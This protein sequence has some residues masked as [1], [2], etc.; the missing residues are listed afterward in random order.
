M[1][2]FVTADGPSHLYTAVI[3]KSLLFHPHSNYASVYRLN[4]RLVPNW[5]ATVVLGIIAS[6]FGDQRAEKVMI[7]LCLCAGFFAFAYA[8]RSFAPEAAP[9][10]PLLNFLLQTWFLCAGFQ[11]FYLGMVLCPLLIGFYVRNAHRMTVRQAAVVAAGLI[12]LFMTHLVAAGFAALVLTVISVWL[13]LAV[14]R[15]FR[16]IGFVMMALTPVAFLFLVFARSSEQSV[17][18]RPTL[19]DALSH[20]PMQVFATA[21]GV[22]GSQTYLWPAV[23]A[24]IIIAILAMRPAEWYGPRGGLALAVLA[25]FALYLAV[26]ENGFG[27]N[28]V[29]VRFSWGFFILGTLL[30]CSVRRLQPLRTPIAIYVAA[31]LTMNLVS[32]AQT[33]SA[34]SLAVEDY[35]TATRGLSRGARFV[36]LRYPTP[37]LPTRYRFNE[38]WR[39]PLFHLDAYVAAR[40]RC[41]DLSDYQA[42]NGVFPVVFNAKIDT[43]QRYSLWSLEGP[44]DRTSETLE[45]LRS[46]LPDP[47]DYVVIVADQ[48]SPLREDREKL[49]ASLDSEMRVV[50]ETPFIRVYG[51]R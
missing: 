5:S 8:I 32:S 12:G 34:Y 21:D 16:Q 20:F 36:R 18:L 6:L 2:N 49:E 27:G 44:G 39:D 31:F 30:A 40:C 25:V 35:L 48:S 41:I 10:T 17:R 28:Q 45:W 50:A 43:N 22:S 7:D 51:K 9:W 37:D 46:H 3:A 13:H 1:P 4:P 38:I 33:V 23:L 26:P 42:P 14:K 29:K 11:N 15:D 47:I 19:A 24:L